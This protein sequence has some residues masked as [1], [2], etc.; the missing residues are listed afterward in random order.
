MQVQ[1]VFLILMVTQFIECIGHTSVK[2]GRLHYTRLFK[3]LSSA[4]CGA[5]LCMICAK[6]IAISKISMTSSAYYH[7]QPDQPAWIPVNRYIS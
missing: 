7:I 6:L 2:Q 4:F 5:K 3:K 1:V